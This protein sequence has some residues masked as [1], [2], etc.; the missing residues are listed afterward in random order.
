MGGRWV[1][2]LAMSAPYLVVTHQAYCTVC[3]RAVED[4]E[5]CINDDDLEVHL[6]CG[7]VVETQGHSPLPSSARC[8]GAELQ[9]I[10]RA[11]KNSEADW[12]AT[13]Y[14]ILAALPGATTAGSHAAS[15]RAAALKVLADGATTGVNQQQP[16]GRRAAARRRVAAGTKCNGSGEEAAKR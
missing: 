12:L 13:Q 11:S 14:A 9:L 3:R 2:E 7:A 16:V 6:G 5:V 15:G 10:D 1:R 8:A 4:E